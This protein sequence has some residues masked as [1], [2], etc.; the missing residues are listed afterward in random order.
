MK[1]RDG[2]VY[3][4]HILDAIAR[5]EEYISGVEQKT[6]SKTLL[7]QDGVIRQVEIIGEAAKRVPSN[8]RSKYTHTPP[9]K[10]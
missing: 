7:L 9:G 5:I 1:E 4:K 2:T 10:I 3:L 6:F 8:L